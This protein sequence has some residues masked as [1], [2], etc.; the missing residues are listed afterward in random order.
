MRVRKNLLIF[1]A[2][3]DTIHV[4]AGFAVNFQEKTANAVEGKV[5]PD[6]FSAAIAVFE[7]SERAKKETPTL[8]LFAGVA[9]V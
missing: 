9:H 3:A 1:T 8:H 6:R 4:S 5:C 7:F 2:D